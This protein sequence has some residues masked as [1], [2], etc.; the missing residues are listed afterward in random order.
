MELELLIIK[1]KANLW[2]IRERIKIARNDI[3]TK[4]PEATAYITGALQSEKELAEAY[5]MFTDL[6]E[7]ALAI[8]R[9]NNV[10]ARRNIELMRRVK[11]LETEVQTNNF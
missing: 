3:E 10:L 5:Q 2:A 1:T 11:E 7:H 8:S 6:Y 4:R 9:E